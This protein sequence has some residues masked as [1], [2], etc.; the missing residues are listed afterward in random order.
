VRPP[1]QVERPAGG[2]RSV[3]LLTEPAVGH[4][5]EFRDF[6]L[7]R[8]RLAD[9]PFAPAP[10]LA[11]SG[12]LYELVFVGYSGSAFPAELRVNALVPGLEPLD[13]AAAETDLWSLLRWIVSEVGGEWTVDGLELTARIYRLS[14]ASEPEGG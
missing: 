9:D 6:F 11:F 10:V 13:E 2:Y 4:Y 14:P 8:F 1:E 5:P 7:R 12:R 3:P